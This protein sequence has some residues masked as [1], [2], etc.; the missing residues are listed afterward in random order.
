MG[1]KMAVD[2]VYHVTTKALYV[3]TAICRVDCS[4]SSHAND[5]SNCKQRIDHSFY[6][7]LC[8][9]NDVKKDF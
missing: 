4:L 3:R 5:G 8:F 6:L 7:I 2:Y 1:P 9:Q